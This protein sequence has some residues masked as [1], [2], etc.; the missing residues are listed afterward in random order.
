MRRYKS[1]TTIRV[2]TYRAR[3]AKGYQGMT[4]GLLEYQKTLRVEQLPGMLLL[5]FG[6]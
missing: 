6:K 3:P 1:F 4:I 2:G 5:P